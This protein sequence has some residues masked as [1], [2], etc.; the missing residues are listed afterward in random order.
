MKL[1]FNRRHLRELSEHVRHSAG[2]AS[3]TW[4]GWVLT[5]SCA[6]GSG[7]SSVSLLRDGTG[8]ASITLAAGVGVTGAGAAPPTVDGGD[9]HGDQRQSRLSTL[10]N[11]NGSVRFFLR[12]SCQC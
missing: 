7:G 10:L 9:G 1:V 6:E 3:S 12:D 5:R 2:A 4:T 8:R 11:E